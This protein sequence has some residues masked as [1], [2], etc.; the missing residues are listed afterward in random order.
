[1]YWYRR[2]LDENYDVVWKPQL[3]GDGSE[4]N[5]GDESTMDAVVKH[6]LGFCPVV[7]VQN[8][9][10]DD[11]IDGDPDCHGVYDMIE[12]I[13]AL[14]SQ[15]SRGILANCDPTV[16][17]S[18]TDQL[19]ELTKGSDNALKLTNGTASYMEISGSGPK[20]A[21]ELAESLR[22][23]VL[24]VAQCI[25][26][27][28]DS[29]GAQTATEIERA[30]SSMLSKADIMREQ[31][32]ERCVKPLMEMMVA[33][34]RKATRAVQ[35]ES[36]IT[37]GALVL[38][39]KISQLPDGTTQRAERKLGPG[40]ALKL[41]WPG[42][43]EPTLTDASQAVGAAGQAKGLGLVDDEHAVKFVAEYFHVEDV[44]A[45]VAKMQ[46][47]AQAQQ[48]SYGQQSLGELGGGGEYAEE[49]PP[50][51]LAPDEAPAA[52]DATKVPLPMTDIKL[53]VE[54]ME[55]I[56]TVNEARQSVGLDILYKADGSAD[57]DGDLSISEYKVKK[58][59]TVAAAANATAG[60]SL[61]PLPGKP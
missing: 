29:G 10:L 7:W 57:P 32:G 17:I 5:W 55:A 31:Y 41:T 1:M 38:P 22:A 2:V 42:Y 39:A 8:Q 30:Y 14:L 47:A 54:A 49:P 51:E 52:D 16:L 27:R 44:S 33:A 24:E 46:A 18:T 3:V 21:L 53:G 19:S 34:A 35:S 20:A 40:G 60:E 50:E 23:K 25:L 28:P 36:G 37:R 26:D 6:N 45:M 61:G 56:V 48:D 43:F 15:A 4:P 12:S 59:G 9:P 13:D 58:A 11:S